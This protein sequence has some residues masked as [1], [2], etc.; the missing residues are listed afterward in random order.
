M[1]LVSLANMKN[2]V[3]YS[4]P[5]H[6]ASTHRP[7]NFK[8]DMT[9]ARL[10]LFWFFLFATLPCRSD[11][12]LI[13]D[14]EKLIDRGSR[15][16]EVNRLVAAVHA[17]SFDND[18]PTEYDLFW[19]APPGAKHRK[20]I[21]VY[22]EKS[23]AM[24]GNR[25][26]SNY[27][28]LFPATNTGDLQPSLRRYNRHKL[29]VFDA[30]GNH[31]KSNLNLYSAHLYDFN[32]DGKLDILFS[33]AKSNEDVNFC[34]I[35]IADFSDA[36]QDAVV[37]RNSP[38]K[39]VTGEDPNEPIW[40]Y[41][42]VSRAKDAPPVIEFIST[43]RPGVVMT[44][45]WDAVKE[46]YL[47]SPNET[48]QKG[49]RIATG[50]PA[51]SGSTFFT[52]QA[53]PA[54]MIRSSREKR[55]ASP[56]EADREPFLYHSLKDAAPGEIQQF[57][58]GKKHQ[59]NQ[60]SEG[61]FPNRIPEQ[62]QDLSPREA[63]LALANAN[64]TGRHK[65]NWQIAV[66]ENR[67]RKEKPEDG[68]IV[69]DWNSSGCYSFSASLTAI[70]FGIDEPFLIS[71]GYNSHGVVDRNS[72]ADI[73]GHTVRMIPLS[74]EEAE[75]FAST[76]FYIHSIR[77]LYLTGDDDRFLGGSTADGFA[78]LR[79]FSATHPSKEITTETIWI[80]QSISESWRSS[81][82]PEVALNLSHF[83]L[84][85]HLPQYLEDRWN[86]SGPDLESRSVTTPLEDRLAQRHEE[87]A[88]R[89]I[90]QTAREILELHLAIDPV[91]PSILAFVISM[92]GEEAMRELLPL[93]IAIQDQLPP[94]TPEEEELQSLDHNTNSDRYLELMKE[95]EFDT[96]TQ[97]RGPLIQSIEKLEALK[98]L[99][100]LEAMASA[101]G[102]HSAW[103]LNQIRNLVPE[104][105]SKILIGHFQKTAAIKAKRTIFSTLAAAHPPGALRLRNQLTG[106][107][108]DELL[109][110]VSDLESK[111][112]SL[113]FQKRIP[114]LFGFVEDRSKD[115][116]RRMTA[117]KMLA[118]AELGDRYFARLER[119]LLNE[120][121]NPHRS[122]D[123]FDS[124]S[125]TVAA[126]TMTPRPEKYLQDF[127]EVAATLTKNEG[128]F[129]YITSYAKDD[130]ERS[131]MMLRAIRPKLK[132]SSGN[133]NE[134][135]QWILLCDLRGLE[136]EVTNF[137]TA[138]PHQR[139]G[140]GADYWGGSFKGPS[141][142]RY[143]IAREVN[144]LWSES[145]PATL[146]K[147]WIAFL[148]HRYSMLFNHDQW[149]LLK[150]R[151]TEGTKGLSDSDVKELFSDMI[152]QQNLDDRLAKS[153][154]EKF[155]KLRDE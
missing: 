72:L 48:L 60:R 18:P 86:L 12:P 27:K 119:L 1:N 2:L 20:L 113:S 126:L 93:L 79:Y 142:Q 152:D 39:A 46:T 151:F 112:D 43:E 100:K 25:Q 4:S 42:V 76:I 106:A 57:F 11:E 141:G 29:L 96:A 16:A 68:W 75:F 83:F 64:R 26:D 129:A 70:R 109:L 61:A 132:K 59:F 110:E 88:R 146:A 97:I 104:I 13:A 90:I 49:L 51:V 130:A 84:S 14:L 134:L 63:A 128:T 55:P 131:S 155:H 34:V 123:F 117:M 105:Y 44:F 10:T 118:S 58:N 101:R 37:P 121:R 28:D 103:A 85:T 138:G 111:H 69:T 66:D 108:I 92:A 120:L 125:S 22:R 99:R 154:R 87:N 115:I 5:D 56:N 19:S 144:A 148:A 45:R 107:Q 116:W 136:S 74:K 80:T 94:P 6:C 30:E 150:Q 133:I 82:S 53:S 15:D 7:S 41:R 8:S 35:Q 145:D 23:F 135:F 40:D 62:L 127:V 24:G 95:L 143:H 139:D 54:S 147:M 77:S 73:P 67:F 114:A 71:T 31:I 140:N 47:L 50:L 3:T 52:S 21:L 65:I 9:L 98:D 124:L 38:F 91:P 81:Y 89:Q 78:S 122:G 17:Y 32:R 149:N 36:L 137:A 33:E 153:V 102:V